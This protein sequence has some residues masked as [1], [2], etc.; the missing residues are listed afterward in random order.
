M[1][2]PYSQALTTIGG[3]PPY[4]W[5]IALGTLPAGVTLNSSTG[6]IGGFPTAP[7]NGTMLTFRVVD[8]SLPAQTSHV[9]LPL[10][11]IPAGLAIST[12]SLSNGTVGT[13][14]SQM[15]S[16]TGGTP[17]YT[18]ILT[19]GALPAGISLNSVTGLISGSPTAS[20][21]AVTLSFTVTDSM[22]PVAQTDTAKVSLTV[23][24]GTGYWIFAELGRERFGSGIGVQHLPQ[25]CQRKRLLPGQFGS[26]FGFGL[27]GRHSCWWAD[28]LLCFEGSG[29][30]R[31]QRRIFQRNTVNS[32]LKNSE[33]PR[34]LKRL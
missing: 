3:T 9:S 7:A 19:V 25:Q 22:T 30:E 11:I 1:G 2:I 14:Y 23:A 13:P 27:Y 6:L 31:Q 26:C 10:T 4:T 8:S 16:A 5:S 28:L 21:N 15:L 18:W 12:T 32:L 33:S 20:A 24:G 34:E 29:F 17:P